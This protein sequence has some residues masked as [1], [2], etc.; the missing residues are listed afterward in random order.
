MAFTEEEKRERKNARQ[1]EY[2]KRTNYAAHV[3]YQK[4]NVKQYTLKFIINTEG[5]MIEHLE[6][7]PN[8]AGYIKALIKK[9][10]ETYR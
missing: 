9:D 3:K 6:K 2:A 1:R 4:A 10:M 5:D 8:K 7:Q